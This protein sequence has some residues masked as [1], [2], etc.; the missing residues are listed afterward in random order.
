MNK[1]VY[2]F[3]YS[4]WDV[5][6]SGGDRIL[7]E[8]ARRLSIKHNVN[9]FTWERA[10]PIFKREK[11][12]SKSIKVYVQKINKYLALGFF[13]HYMIR[14]F[15]SIKKGFS[16][17]NVDD[18]SL[19]YSSS[20]FLM[21]IFPCVI[22]KIRYPKTRWIA[23]WYMTAPNPLRGYQ[24][25]K[26]GESR[27][28][29]KA[30]IYFLSQ[31]VS[32]PFLKKFADYIIVNNEIEKKNFTR[33]SKKGRVIVMLGGLN[34]N[35]INKYLKNKKKSSTKNIDSVFIGRFHPQK[36]V[37]ELI[38]IW[39]I[40]NRKISAR[41]VLIGDGPLKDKVIAKIKEKGLGTKI[42]L[43]GYL[44]DGEKKYSIFASSKLV[45]HPAFYDSGGMAAGEAMA[46]GVPGVGFGLSAFKSY[47]PKGMIFAKKG[48]K[49]DF[50]RKII[51]LLKDR[52][53]REKLGKEAQNMVQDWGW[54]N[55]FD[56]IIAEI[57]KN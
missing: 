16:L 43:E 15:V 35:L 14:I 23:T 47:Y 6:Y 49:A 55:K 53:R 46:F 36:G 52:K 10:I 33:L 44:F 11:L 29:I 4:M 3:A 17:K 5:G 24:E 30:L 12:K 20:D 42:K 34:I 19:L 27:Y 39:E 26:E 45:L 50:A 41:L 37:L 18:D 54:E 1:S 51:E 9:I 22:L 2:M 57:C 21:D 31:K 28:R 40:V 13:M 32:K 25:D 48:D 56:K 8:F 7:V 38:D